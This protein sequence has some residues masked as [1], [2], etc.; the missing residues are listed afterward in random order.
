MLDKVL[1]RLG[2]EGHTEGKGQLY[3]ILRP[4]L[5]GQRENQPYADLGAKLGLTGSEGWA[6]YQAPFFLKAGQ[7][8]DLLKLNVVVEGRGRVFIKDVRVIRGPPQPE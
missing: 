4:C 3:E 5:I 8:P 1:A 2:D 7:N 6:T